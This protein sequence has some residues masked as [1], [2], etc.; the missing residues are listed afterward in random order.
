MKVLKKGDWRFT[1]SCEECHAFL[2]GVEEDLVTRH[3]DLEGGGSVQIMCHCPECTT[4]HT[5]GPGTLPEEVRDRVLN[6][7]C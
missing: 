5:F 1:F 6:R 3:V 7:K 4:L 2:V